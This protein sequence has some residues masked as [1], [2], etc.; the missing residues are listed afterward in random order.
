L[1]GSS[2]IPLSKTSFNDMK[3]NNNHSDTK[4]NQVD[5][6]QLSE[7]EILISDLEFF[8]D[9]DMKSINVCILIL[10]SIFFYQLFINSLI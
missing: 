3:N 7:R 4:E 8:L 6:S 10:L 9:F 1:S 5:S 2:Q